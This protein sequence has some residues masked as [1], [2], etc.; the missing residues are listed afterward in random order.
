LLGLHLAFLRAAPLFF[1]VF[2]IFF[3]PIK[4]IAKGNGSKAGKFAS[5]GKAAMCRLG[6]AFGAAV[7][8]PHCGILSLGRRAIAKKESSKISDALDANRSR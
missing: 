7:F 8:L 4:H 6:R 5:L 1:V 3:I 2:F